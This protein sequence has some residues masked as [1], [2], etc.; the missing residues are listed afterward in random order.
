MQNFYG[1]ILI[2]CIV[3][4]SMGLQNDDM[5]WVPFYDILLLHK[6]DLLGVPKCCKRLSLYLLVNLFYFYWTV[7]SGTQTRQH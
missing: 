3:I 2:K 1:I 7:V 6:T 5:F 4:C